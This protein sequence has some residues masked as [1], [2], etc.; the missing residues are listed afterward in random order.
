M[1]KA[2]RDQ[3]LLIVV[4]AFAL[5][6]FGVQIGIPYW[7]MAAIAGGYLVLMPV[8]QAVL[9]W[10]L[11][12]RGFELVIQWWPTFRFDISFPK[13]SEMEED[14]EEDFDIE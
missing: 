6:I 1:I 13:S 11:R 12:D 5:L 4:V 7:G 2:I 9:M 10:A 3:G 8:L 14:D